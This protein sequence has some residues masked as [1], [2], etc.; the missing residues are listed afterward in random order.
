MTS[1]SSSQFNID[2]TNSQIQ[3]TEQW[4]INCENST[5]GSQWFEVMYGNN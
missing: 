1:L 5:S 3:E 4:L 2:L